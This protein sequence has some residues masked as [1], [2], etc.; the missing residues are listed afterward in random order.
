[1]EQLTY[2]DLL[3]KVCSRHP[4]YGSVV[5]YCF[6]LSA[7][8]MEFFWILDWLEK[9]YGYISDMEPPESALGLI[10]KKFLVAHAEDDFCFRLYAYQ[11]K[12]YQLLNAV[13][14]IGL[15]ERDQMH[16]DNIRNWLGTNEP[17]LLQRLKYFKEHSVIRGMIEQRQ[18][19]T[20]RLSKHDIQILGQTLRY[21]EW[22]SWDPDLDI[23]AE[24]DQVDVA[25]DSFRVDDLYTRT[26][27]K[28]EA[29]ERDLSGFAHALCGD[30][31][32]SLSRRGLLKEN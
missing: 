11:E 1:M 21:F 6:E 3:V 19:L 25:L 17:G 18:A 29:V 31:L 28:L 16:R 32:N 12:V 8:H 15:S 4:N 9:S 22:L 20:H 23:L 27:T 7:L 26:K 5:D 10:H 2:L 30:V 24:K 14:N 13:F